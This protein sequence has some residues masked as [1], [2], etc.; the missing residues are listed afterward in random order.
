[1]AGNI[2]DGEMRINIGDL[3][4]VARTV[5]P[6][7]LAMVWTGPHQV[8]NAVSKFV[9]E[10]EPMLAHKG[11]QRREIV[12]IVR[13]RRF[14]NGLLGSPADARAIE[15]AALHDYPDNVVQRF[16]EHKTDDS[17]TFRL[18][19]RWLGY[20]S[21]HDS[22]EPIANMVEDVPN[23]VQEYLTEHKDQPVCARILHTYFPE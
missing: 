20:D 10:T 22:F 8:V 14:S 6:H 5:Q 13:I 9:Y 1:M 23:R 3:V 18:K 7:K 15:Q 11:R 21:A 4:L 12:H 19:V 16:L 2:M 17:G